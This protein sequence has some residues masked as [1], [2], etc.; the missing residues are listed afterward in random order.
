M[1]QELVFLKRGAFTRKK[2]NSILF[3]L[4][5]AWAVSFIDSC[6]DTLLAGILLDE[7]AVSAVALVQPITSVISFLSYLVS[8]GT[9]VMFSRESGAF[10][11]DKAYKYVGQGFI[12]SV[13]ISIF[14]VIAMILIREP[15]LAYYQASAEITELAR[16]YYFCQIIFAAIYPVYFI[17]YQIIA[18]DGDETCGFIASLVSAITNIYFSYTLSLTYG[19]KGLSYGS[20]IGV[21]AAIMVY[22]TH[23]IKKSNSIRVKLYFNMQELWEVIKIGSATAMTLL[24]IAIIDIVMNRFVI[25]MFGDIYLPAYAVVNFI[26]N[27]G[28]VFSGL[29]DACSGFIGVAHGENNPESIRQTMRIS[30][31]G[32][33]IIS[34]IMLI[35][36]EYIAP[37]V[38]DLY[39][40]SDPIVRSA[41][42]YAARIIPLSF[43]ALAVYYLFGSYYPLVGYVWL[44][45]VI[46]VVY[47][48]IAPIALAMPLGLMFGFNGM[49]FGFM[50]TCVLADIVVFIIVRVKYGKKAVP[51]ILPE[52]DEEA[53]FYE[54][55][56][57]E[58]NIS[59]LCETVQ[60]QL[61]KRHI[62]SSINNEVQ[63]IL[64]ES[65]MK[66]MKHNKG[67]KVYTECNLLISESSLRLITRDNGKIFDITDAD[68]KITDFRS[69][70]V[71]QVMQR[72]PERLNTTTISFNR[73]SY[74][75]KLK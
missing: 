73:N 20:I 47:M 33:A 34:L 71:A 15:Y 60:K 41:A 27:M 67:R 68:A 54:L 43:P 62:P 1:K 29:Y 48:L 40:I 37:Y 59:K 75:W 51:L 8:V 46:S 50:L 11:R 56:L 2:Y 45:H 7:T 21:V 72:N 30:Y 38:P 49:S 35:V 74:S 9:V 22:G 10:N 13:G 42:I 6:A 63:L 14:L 17:I 44:G 19:I 23:F 36:I 16:Q 18:I 24:Y 57:T 39:G 70:V 53:I 25:A 4:T 65:Y 58:K 28:A 55:V 26:L 32:A 61:E 66:I 52:T 12:A 69:Y 31:R 5:L 3:A 64:E